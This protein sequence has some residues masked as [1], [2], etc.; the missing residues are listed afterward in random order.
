[1][2]RRLPAILILLAGLATPGVLAAADAK[3]LPLIPYPKQIEVKG[4]FVLPGGA[5]IVVADKSLLPLANVL[6]EELHRVGAAVPG[7][8][9]GAPAKGDIELRI[10]PGSGIPT[11]SPWATA[12][13]SPA[14]TTPRSLRGRPRCCRR[15]A[16]TDR[17][18]EC[19]ACR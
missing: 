1:M 18:C 7:V 16:G 3:T 5:R 8:A 9:A 15:P 2:P 6:A 14:R 17:R 10:D 13:S 19:R 12:S 4:E 11:R